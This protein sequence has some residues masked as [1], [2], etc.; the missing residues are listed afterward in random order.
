M[1]KA[2]GRGGNKEGCEDGDDP[3]DDDRDEALEKLAEALRANPV[4]CS[5][6]EVSRETTAS[7]AICHAH[8]CVRNHKCQL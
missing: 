5:R 1:G 7:W 8:T 6:A 2:V 3:W 4:S